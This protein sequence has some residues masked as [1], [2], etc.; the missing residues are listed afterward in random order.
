MLPR[1]WSPGIL[2]DSKTTQFGKPFQAITPSHKPIITDSRGSEHPAL[3]RENR[4]KRNHGRNWNTSK[5]VNSPHDLA[6]GPDGNL[7]VT[8]FGN[9]RVLCYDG[10][11][12][13]FLTTVAIGGGLGA[14]FPAL[15]FLSWTAGSRL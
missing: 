1:A 15:V 13:M 6:F 5:R 11:T 2:T 14:R 4:E 10:K 7:Y 9:Q 3:K 8:S 12:G